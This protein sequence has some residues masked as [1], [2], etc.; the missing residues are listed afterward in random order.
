[1]TLAGFLTAYKFKAHNILINTM[2]KSSQRN[3]HIK[4][5]IYIYNKH[6]IQEGALDTFG[7]LAN[8]TLGSE[9]LQ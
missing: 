9:Q 5:Y 2:L 4:I 1:M 7:S 3:T 6:K 8:G